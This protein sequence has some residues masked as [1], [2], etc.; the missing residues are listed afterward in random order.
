MYKEQKIMDA[1][2]MQAKG[3]QQEVIVRILGV[4]VRTVRNYQKKSVVIKEE[5]IHLTS[6]NR[7]LEETLAC[8]RIKEHQFRLKGILSRKKQLLPEILRV[9][10]GNQ[11]STM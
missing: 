7:K 3:Y 8:P 5:S 9:L 6:G 1:K 4:S 2:I 11:Q 10:E